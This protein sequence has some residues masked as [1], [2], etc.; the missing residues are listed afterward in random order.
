MVG[1]TIS[2]YKVTA[3]L[4]RGSMGVVYKA[5]DLKLDRTVALKF[6]APHLLSNE[7]AQRR[8]IREAKAAAALDHPN[9]CTVYEIDDF[10]GQMFI[11]MAFIEG[12]CLDDSVKAG[13]LKLSAVLDIAIQA[14]EG[15]KHAHKRNVVHR[16]IKSANI[17]LSAEGPAKILDFGLARLAQASRLTKDD[18][19]MGTPAYM[20]PE[21]ASGN[22][23]DRR[24]DIWSLGVVLYETVSGR[25]PFPGD[26]HQAVLYSVLNEDPEPLS[27]LRTGVPRELDQIISKALT[28]DPDERYQHMDDLLVD[29][30]ALHKR[31]EAGAAREVPGRAEKKIKSFVVAEKAGRRRWGVRVI[32]ATALVLLAA[33]T[34]MWLTRPSADRLRPVM[35]RL[36][37]DADLTFEPAISPDGKLVAY[38]SDRSGEG[39]LDLWMRQVDGGPPIRLTDHETDDHSPHFSPDGTR[40]AFRSERDGGGIYVVSTLGGDAQLIAVDGRNPQFSPDGQHIAYWIG[41]AGDYFVG[42]MYIAA[43]AGGTPQQLR[44]D[45]SY[46]THPIWHPDGEVLLFRGNQTSS[47]SAWWVTPLDG[48]PAVDIRMFRCSGLAAPELIDFWIP[49]GWT[50]DGN[51]ILFSARLGDSTNIWRLPISTESWQVSCN[52]ERLTSGIGEFQPSMAADG[53]LV[54]ASVV[55][56]VDVWSLPVDADSATVTGEI[57][58]VTRDG[59]MDSTASV[60]ADGKIISF[61]SNRSGHFDV[62]IKNLE[63]GKLAAL[64]TSIRSAASFPVLSADGSRLAYTMF[65]SN[66][67]PV[68]SV[69]VLSGESCANGR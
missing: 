5:E 41:V 54:F 44:S 26:Y 13:L 16:D 21:Q 24:T 46:A 48:G 33:G 63:T 23:G 34:A 55:R 69:A 17:M 12:Q 38:A 62:W 37:S 58:Q 59:A 45:F 53:R 28:K 14:G 25:L 39:N 35:R 68:Y 4:G 18:S 66:K 43:A 47:Q 19:Q 31:L 6:L 36:T 51:H 15:L 57:E 52:A 1:E 20:S 2:H 64:G 61:A 22:E 67:Y 56:N 40:I 10:G 65:G 3:E 42:K 60:S 32:L 29:L 27:A 7:E 30:R 49:S 11:A 9:I 50:P 8:F